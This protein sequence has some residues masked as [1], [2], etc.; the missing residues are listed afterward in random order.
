MYNAV[1]SWDDHFLASR[2]EDTA[3]KFSFRKD[4]LGYYDGGTCSDPVSG[5][6]VQPIQAF[7]SYLSQQEVLEAYDRK[8]PLYGSKA[9]KLT[10]DTSFLPDSGNFFIPS[11]SLEKIKHLKVKVYGGYV[12]QPQVE[13]YLVYGDTCFM[14]PTKYGQTVPETSNR[15]KDEVKTYSS[16]YWRYDMQAQHWVSDY[17][18]GS[19]AFQSPINVKVA[20]DTDIPDSVYEI[21]T[22]KE[23]S[24]ASAQWTLYLAIA[25]HSG[26]PR[27][28]LSTVNDVEILIYSY[29]NTRHD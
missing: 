26:R 15:V 29:F 1:V 6:L 11:R 25:S 10:F 14:R 18:F 7:K 16:R 8:N 12:D 9:I 2:S 28:D 3:K 17:T 27:I 22:F 23:F 20:N 24:V 13:G 4:F 21:D 19:Q 5:Q